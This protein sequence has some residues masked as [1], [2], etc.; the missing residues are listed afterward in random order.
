MVLKTPS[1]E[2]RVSKE[3]SKTAALFE[4]R[5]HG[6][7]TSSS[8][9]VRKAILGNMKRSTEQHGKQHKNMHS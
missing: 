7:S 5:I 4:G 9:M 2:L 8:A 6:K 1:K 3:A